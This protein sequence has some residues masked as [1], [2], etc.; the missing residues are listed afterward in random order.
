MCTFERET[1]RQA[2]ELCAPGRS[3]VPL[4]KG[5]DRSPCNLI[6]KTCHR[7]CWLHRPPPFVHK[8]SHL[9]HFCP[10]SSESRF[11]LGPSHA[12]CPG[13]TWVSTLHNLHCSLPLAAL[14]GLRPRAVPPTYGQGAPHCYLTSS[15]LS[16]LGLRGGPTYGRN[17][18]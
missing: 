15:T 4:E 6:Q 3:K 7:L 13:R 16:I 14:R 12:L 1:Q 10:R 2:V 5:Q 17:C 18:I 8:M 9:L 11:A